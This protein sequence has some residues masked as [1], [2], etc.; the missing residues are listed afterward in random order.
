MSNYPKL[1]MTYKQAIKT[2]TRHAKE[3]SGH[4]VESMVN[5]VARHEGNKAAREFAREAVSKGI[6]QRE[7]GKKYF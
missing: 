6:E 4:I 3:G 7:K 2:A 1:G 5:Q